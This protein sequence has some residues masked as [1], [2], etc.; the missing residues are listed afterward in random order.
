MSDNINISDYVFGIIV[1]VFLLTL[2]LGNLYVRYKDYKRSKKENMET[3]KTPAEIKRDEWR[4]K[5]DVYDKWREEEGFRSRC[6]SYPRYP[7]GTNGNER[8]CSVYIKTPPWVGIPDE[9]SYTVITRDGRILAL[10]EDLYP[11]I[12]GSMLFREGE[13]LKIGELGFLPHDDLWQ[14]SWR[15][16]PPETIFEKWLK[17]QEAL[18]K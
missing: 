7:Y 8:D 6:C 1:S 14:K 3:A 11:E 13:C 5:M 17:I 12:A 18:S 15:L 4:K 9:L 2:L 10:K 16:R